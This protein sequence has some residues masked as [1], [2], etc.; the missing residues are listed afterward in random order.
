MDLGSQILQYLLSGITIGAIYAIVALGIVT[1]F[2]VTGIIN[3][4][5]GEF[6]MLGGMVSYWLVAGLHLPMIVGFVLAIIVTTAVGLGV[7]SL[8]LRP[9]RKPTMLSLIIITIGASMF[10]RGIAGNLWGKDAVPMPPFSGDKPIGIFG[11]SIQP[12][13]FWVLGITVII[14]I[15]LTLFLTHTVPGKAVRACALNRQAARIVGIDVRKMSAMIFAISAL[16]GAIGGII[17]A[18]MTMAS[19]DMGAMLELKGFAAAAMGGLTSGVGAVIGGL[20]LGVLESLGTG[21]VSSAYKDAIALVVMFLVLFLR[22]GGIMG[23]KGD[24]K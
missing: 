16:M 21:L 9:A 12:Q 17:V 13:A 6:V 11:A 4:A 18:P 22:P 23:Q 5:Q 24:S 19:Y 3:F 1:I 8:A 20:L 2:N 14:M 7:D 10:I 15:A